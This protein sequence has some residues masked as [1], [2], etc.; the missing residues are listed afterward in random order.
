MPLRTI[1]KLCC[2]K[3]SKKSYCFQPGFSRTRNPF[4]LAVSYYS[5]PVFVQ[6]PN[7]GILKILELLLHSNIS[8]SDNTE[9]QDWACNSQISTFELSTIIMKYEMRVCSLTIVRWL[10]VRLY[11]CS[12]DQF[13]QIVRSF[14][15]AGFS[16]VAE[17]KSKY[18]NKIDIKRDI[19]VAISNI[20]VW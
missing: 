20:P 15:E 13:R 5:E 1:M 11:F 6:L 3:H 2:S 17:I 10:L 18:G 19:R 9:I 14:C 7:P 12:I 4:F 8:D 16:A